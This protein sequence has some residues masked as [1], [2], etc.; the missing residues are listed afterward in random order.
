M[1]DDRCSLLKMEFADCKKR[2]VIWISALGKNGEPQELA[3]VAIIAQERVDYALNSSKFL[4]HSWQNTEQFNKLMD[5]SEKLGKVAEYY[6]TAEKAET[7]YEALKQI[8]NAMKVLKEDQIIIEK[9]AAAAEAFDKLFLGFGTLAKNFP[10][11]FDSTVGEFLF[12]L[13][14]AN[15]FS[16]MNERMFG[17][18]TNMGRA[19]DMLNNNTYHGYR[20]DQ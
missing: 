10:P 6:Q 14:S 13:G 18:N 1:A 12:E 11:P 20:L 16:N 19:L 4:Q 5:V 15:F 8:Y 2:V 9:P 17:K 7:N 3:K